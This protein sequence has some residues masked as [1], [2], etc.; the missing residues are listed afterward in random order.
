MAP[1]IIHPDALSLVGSTPLIRLNRIP[2]SRGI[3]CN[4]LVK[5]E[6][7]NPGGSVKDRIAARMVESAERS[8]RLVPGKSVIVEPT[9]GNTGIGLAMAAAVRGYKCI[10]VLPEK[11][12]KEKVHTMKA[13]GAQVVRTPT[14]AA[15][16]DPRSNIMVARR[17]VTEMPDA[18]MLDQYN[19]PDN[20]LAHEMTAEEIIEAV[21]NGYKMPDAADVK[22]DAKANA[23]ASDQAAV[24]QMLPDPSHRPLTPDSAP[25]LNNN[26]Q[27]SESS[28]RLVDVFVAGVGTGGTITGVAKR[29]KQADHNPSCVVVGVDPIG[30]TLA[31]PAS[32]NVLPEG[33]TGAYQQE[34]VGYDF[35]PA[36]LDKSY[37]DTW[38][39]TD[40]DESFGMTR[41]LIR[42]EGILAGGSSGGSVSAAMRWLKTDGWEKFGS[43]SGK[44]VVIILADGIRNYGECLSAEIIWLGYPLT[45]AISSILSHE[46]LAPRG[47]LKS[48]TF[49]TAK[50]FSQRRT[51]TYCHSRHYT[52][53]TSHIIM[54]P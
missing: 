9:S 30:S 41:E 16:D 51:N 13:L 3:H 2:P 37:I 32:L 52:F 21:Q 4:V 19:N 48:R 7:F 34:G 11:M 25:E 14:E 39:K 46:G 42:T 24:E 22:R 27:E 10:I 5:C 1:P 44:N 33:S 31:L 26:E 36:V 50:S 35:D 15:H 17:M 23:K 38:V 12:S 45:F 40:D 54:R 18:V 49:A 8:G 20:P 53:T 43:Q 6:F 29:L 28:S 47:Q